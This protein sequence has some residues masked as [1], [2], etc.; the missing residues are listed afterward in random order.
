MITEL[1]Q[2]FIKKAETHSIG[3]PFRGSPT[4][5]VNEALGTR[6]YHGLDIK[7]S[8]GQGLA[9]AVPWIG[10]FAFGQRTEKGIYPV[11]LYFKEQL[12]LVL[13][14]G[15]SETH[16]PDRQW[17]NLDGKETIREYFAQHDLGV[18]ARYG[19][20]YVHSVYDTRGDLDEAEIERD[21]AVVIG[22][23]SSVFLNDAT[24]KDK[25]LH[26]SIVEALGS[27]EINI[28]LSDN[29][30]RF[31][32]ARQLLEEF[33]TF[34]ATPDFLNQLWLNYDSARGD[35]NAKLNNFAAASDEF[36]LLLL[37]GKL[38]S[39]CDKN[40]ANKNS[41]NE[42]EDK[43][44]I[45][46]AG[47][48]QGNWIRNLIAY[49]VNGNSKES[50]P[51]IIGNALAYLKNPT[52]ELTMLSEQH[53]KMV[54]RNLLENEAYEKELFVGEVLDY[55]RPYSIT[56]QNPENLTRVISNILYQ[57]PDVKALWFDAAPEGE[58]LDL[59]TV[60][61]EESPDLNGIEFTTVS[62]ASDKRSILTAIRTKPFV[63]LA[64]LSGTGK[65]RL[66]RTL[67][68]ATCFDPRLRND[69]TKPGNFE[70]ITVKPNWHDST[71]LMG[72][73]SRI[74]GEKYLSTAFLKFV[75]KA[76]RF[77]HVPF[78]LC[79][80]EM[81]LAPVE[82][83]FAEYL[84]I[85]ETRTRDGE[86]L[87]SDYLLARSQFENPALYDGLI[88]D[89]GLVGQP[90]FVEGLALP[91]NLIVIGTVNMDETTHSFSRK[92]LDRAM[93]FEMNQVD[94]RAGL[95]DGTSDWSYPEKFLDPQRVIPEYSGGSEVFNLYEESKS[96]IDF[97]ERLN[98]ILDGT[99]FKIAYRVRDEFLVYCYYSS[100]YKNESEN[101][102]NRS[103]DE[104][105]AMKIL[106][107]IEGDEGKTSRVLSE[108]DK[109]LNGD[110]KITTSK[111]EEMRAR[112]R[113]SGYTSFWS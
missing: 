78:F 27:P 105:T 60:E 109:V 8:F 92:V 12:R 36:R 24:A 74:S 43:R 31:Q 80:D 25:S 15:V 76:W 26:A 53:R 79:L 98:D 72:Y 55:F 108:F 66:V 7:A 45:A 65:S 17:T 88:K 102:L 84:S 52:T 23:F 110:F 14:Y 18:P 112:L 1:L 101:W 103:L 28:V 30:F 89:L 73:V 19:S 75:A 90:S 46:R 97:L 93:T 48:R 20:S 6:S 62:F 47:I 99:P 29:E 87:R 77:L 63:L 94:L 95:A 44:T 49:K 39:Y 3:Q 58:E 4:E 106:S 83:Y 104:M 100:L 82:Q 64:G 5:I 51:P 34:P 70:L 113:S 50:I 33:E 107:R 41:Y 57:F 54:S 11:F 13:A 2:R 91:S 40:A 56:P 38:I 68:F 9:T 37:M 59:P 42:Y 22:E 81:N 32:K 86:T 35:F 16:S 10:F 71:E 61:S 67:A 111:L 85:L 21:L 96:V 69:S